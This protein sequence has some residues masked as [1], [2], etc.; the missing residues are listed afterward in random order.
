[1]VR[2]RAISAG[3]D[4]HSGIAEVH[5]QQPYLAMRPDQYP[6]P[7]ACDAVRKGVPMLRWN[8]LLVLIFM[9]AGLTSLMSSGAHAAAAHAIYRGLPYA[10]KPQVVMACGRLATFA[11]WRWRTRSDEGAGGH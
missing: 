4:N 3:L 9:F 1:M 5:C 8:K 10:I 7:A 2:V 6:R 11:C